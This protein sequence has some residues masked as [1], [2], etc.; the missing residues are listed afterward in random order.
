[1]NKSVSELTTEERKA[2]VNDLGLLLND[3]QIPSDIKV[4]HEVVCNLQSGE[5]VEHNVSL[6]IRKELPQSHK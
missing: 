6:V 2:L 4:V 1:M 5:P 3:H